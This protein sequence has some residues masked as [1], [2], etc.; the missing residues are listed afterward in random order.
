L[1]SQGIQNQV[2]LSNGT[3]GNAE[4]NAVNKVLYLRLS[5]EHYKLLAHHASEC[6]KCGG[7]ETRCPFGVKIIEGMEKAAELFGY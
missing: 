2:I 1:Q 4:G 7:C 6:V 5:R 3:Q